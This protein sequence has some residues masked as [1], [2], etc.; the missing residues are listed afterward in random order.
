MKDV[1]LK[2]RKI[3]LKLF[4]I[5]KLK[6][7]CNKIFL[8]FPKFVYTINLFLFSI[9][10]ESSLQSSTTFF[11][12]NTAANQKFPATCVVEI[13]INNRRSKIV[14]EILTVTY[15]MYCRH[16]NKKPLLTNIKNLFILK[17]R[18]KKKKKKK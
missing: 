18:R 6:L 1:N 17:L 4:E 8:I 14:P 3:Y 5:T 15:F 16:V 9:L 13:F 10:R 12:R 11:W 7:E 2:R